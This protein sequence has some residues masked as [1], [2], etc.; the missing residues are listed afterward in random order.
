VESPFLTRYREF[1][2]SGVEGAVLRDKTQ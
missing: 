2:S 1:A